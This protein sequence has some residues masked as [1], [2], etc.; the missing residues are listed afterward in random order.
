MATCDT[1]HRHPPPTPGT[2]KACLALQQ[3]VEAPNA[4]PEIYAG[5]TGAG[6]KFF[7]AGADLALP[8]VTR[9]AWVMGESLAP[10]GDPR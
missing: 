8:M 6:D 5:A 9:D 1:G 3:V 10:L 4:S 7:S 2:W